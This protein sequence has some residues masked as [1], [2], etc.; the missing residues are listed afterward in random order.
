M[1]NFLANGLKKLQRISEHPEL[2]RTLNK[3]L[4]RDVIVSMLILKKNLGF[5]PGTIVDVGAAVGMW[6]RAAHFVFPEAHS[7][8]FEPI[9]E[10]FSKLEAVKQTI[11]GLETFNLALG[12]RSGEADFNLNDFVFSSSLL[13]MTDH[14][15]EL[16][17]F[18][19]VTKSVKVQCRRFD[20]LPGIRLS[21]PVLLKLDVQGAEMLVLDGCGTLL[22]QIDTVLLE[23]SFDSFYDQQ[24]TVP[25]VFSFMYRRGFK[26]F[27][28]INPQYKNN[29]LLYCDVI[30]MR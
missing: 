14:H 28:Q 6:I 16:F 8:A 1:Q 18:S 19:K 26:R 30:F 15:K 3:G 5:I 24:A 29:A 10:N 7:Y 23:L 4:D 17:P 12:D 27:L 2:L 25:D 13:S 9:P 22:D 21:S 11:P 20:E